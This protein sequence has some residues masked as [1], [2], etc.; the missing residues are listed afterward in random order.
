MWAPHEA[1]SASHAEWMIFVLRLI[2]ALVAL[3]GCLLSAR[4]AEASSDTHW[5]WPLAPAPALVHPFEA[6]RSDYG[7]GHRGI[8]LAGSSGQ[9]VLSATGGLVT[10]A[11][12]VASRGVV[13]V[14]YGDLRLTYEPLAPSVQV[15]DR[16]AAGTALG[17]L[18]VTGSHCWPDPCLHLGLRQGEVYLDPLPYFGPRPVRL[19][20]IVGDLAPPG[21]PGL[22]PSHRAAPPESGADRAVPA[23]EEDSAWARSGPGRLAGAGAAAA[24]AALTV[25]AVR[26]RGQARG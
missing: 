18:A 1:P 23:T 17:S 13:V 10:F 11:S 2:V 19:K 24:A 6:P 7:P 22:P 14:R 8:D 12:R 9:P 25:V 3:V 4:A 16:V 26:R 21:G 20:P 5:P 15:G